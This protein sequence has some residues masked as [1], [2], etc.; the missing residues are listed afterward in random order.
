VQSNRELLDALGNELETTFDWKHPIFMSARM[1]APS[2]EFFHKSYDSIYLISDDYKQKQNIKII[3]TLANPNL[4][5]QYYKIHLQAI[6]L[7][8]VDFYPL[9]PSY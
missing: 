8:L 5:P 9:P 7:M 6:S 3:C 2:L 4:L 1:Y